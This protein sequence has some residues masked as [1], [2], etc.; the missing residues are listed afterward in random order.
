[1]IRC[2][3]RAPRWSDLAAALLSRHTPALWDEPA[4]VPTHSGKSGLNHVFSY[5]RTTKVLE[6]K[7]SKILTPPWL[8]YWVYNAMRSHGFPVLHDDPEVKVAL[9]YHQYGF[10]QDLD[11]INDYCSRRGLVF[12]EDCAHALGGTYKGRPLGSD[13]LAA[14]FSLSKFYPS[15]IGGA[16]RSRDAALRAHVEKLERA[17]SVGL[18]LFSFGIKLILQN[19]KLNANGT[20]IRRRLNELAY[21][22][23]P[24]SRRL[25]WSGKICSLIGIRN[26]L[27][28]RRRNYRLYRELLPANEELQRL[29]ED[30]VPYVLPLMHPRREALDRMAVALCTMGVDTSIHA[31]D[32]NRNLFN[33]RYVPCLWLPV[34]GGIGEDLIERI[35]TIVKRES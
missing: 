6:D 15:L 13:G 10:P 14:I 17:G 21:A 29:E 32:V 1:M 16:V 24:Y 25:L 3:T 20:G 2:D 35:A 18:G 9:V 5:L 28:L 23:Y 30:A 11:E 12:I 22:G 26:E 4:H 7:N 31:F 33:T 8:G 27:D 34:H 19:S